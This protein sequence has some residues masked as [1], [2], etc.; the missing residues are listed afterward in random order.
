MKYKTFKPNRYAL[1]TRDADLRLGNTLHVIKLSPDQAMS[2]KQA[3]SFQDLIN[4]Y[5]QKNVLKENEFYDGYVAVDHGYY[6]EVVQIYGKLIKETN[7]INLKDCNLTDAC[8]RG[9]LWKVVADNCLSGKFKYIW[10]FSDCPFEKASEHL[11]EKMLISA[12]ISAESL[13][14]KVINSFI[15]NE[16]LVINEDEAKV[17][18]YCVEPYFSKFFTKL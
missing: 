3:T 4:I 16:N 8:K 14:D 5:G 18:Q 12:E 7:Y 9:I 11:A 13:R 1:E 6:Q 10:T 2:F 17:L 15:N